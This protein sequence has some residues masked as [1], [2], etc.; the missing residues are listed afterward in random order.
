MWFWFLNKVSQSPV[1]QRLFRESYKTHFCLEANLHTIEY[2]TSTN[3]LVDK[4]NK[5]LYTLNSTYLELNLLILNKLRF[6]LNQRVNNH[7][8]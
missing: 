5:I 3:K 7:R 8:L 1:E 4:I 2:T 6:Y